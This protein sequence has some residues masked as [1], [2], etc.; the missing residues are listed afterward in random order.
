MNNRVDVTRSYITVYEER[1]DW[2]FQAKRLEDRD[3][4]SFLLNQQHTEPGSKGDDVSNA[5]K[6]RCG[7]Q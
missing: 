6:L 4:A 3:E 2:E 1:F 5:I 7:T